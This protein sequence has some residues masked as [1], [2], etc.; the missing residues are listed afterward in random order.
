MFIPNPNHI[1]I[2]DRVTITHDAVFPFGTFTAG[3]IFMVVD[4]L[5]DR[6]GHTTLEVTSVDPSTIGTPIHEKL[7]FLNK[8]NCEKTS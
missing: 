1:N 3:H 5:S 4:I 7:L 6:L 2:G 8:A